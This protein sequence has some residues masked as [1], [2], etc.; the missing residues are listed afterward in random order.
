MGSEE[1]EVEVVEEERGYGVV[2]WEKIDEEEEENGEKCE[3]MKKNNGDFEKHNW[4]III[5][6]GVDVL[7]SSMQFEERNED[8]TPKQ[9]TSRVQYPSTRREIERLFKKIQKV[10]PNLSRSN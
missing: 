6:D 3:E 5:G 7:V 8:T 2:C 4:D 9:V 10:N 1:G